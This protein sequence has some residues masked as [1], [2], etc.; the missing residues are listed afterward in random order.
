M[1]LAHTGRKS[2]RIRRTPV[3]YALIGDVYCVAGFG[4]SADLD[5][6]SLATPAVEVWLP[7]G[8]YTGVAERRHRAAGGG[9]SRD[10]APGVDQQRLRCTHR[11]H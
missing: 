4:Q 8:W 5:R 2:G 6:N 3:N 9:E 7:A 1:V 11:R 10:S